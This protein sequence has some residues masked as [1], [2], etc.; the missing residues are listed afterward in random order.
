MNPTV[1]PNLETLM[2]GEGSTVD[3]HVFW[4]G[5]IVFENIIHFLQNELP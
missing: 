4:L 3:L 1:F 2:K 5:A